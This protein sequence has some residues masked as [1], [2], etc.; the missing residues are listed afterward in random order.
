MQ[1]TGPGVTFPMQD[2]IQVSLQIRCP[3]IDLPKESVRGNISSI[4]SWTL[5]ALAYGS[6][7]ASNTSSELGYLCENFNNLSSR[8][9][10][11]FPEPSGDMSKFA[12][13][14]ICSASKAADPSPEPLAQ[15]NL[16][17]MKSYLAA[18]FVIQGYN[19]NLLNSS[20]YANMCWYL[21][22]SLLQGLWAPCGDTDESGVDVESSFCAS[23]GYYGKDDYSRYT[24]A[25]Q[26]TDSVM[27]ADRLVTML[28]GK[29]L[30][31]LLSS[32]KQFEY[33]CRNFARYEP[34]IRSLGLLSQV[35]R[36]EICGNGGVVE[37]GVAKQSL[38][39]AM[40]NLFSFQ[41]LM[42]GN[43]ADYP[44]FL[45]QN[46]NRNGLAKVGLDGDKILARVC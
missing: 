24:N 35:A 16:W 7:T 43:A 15:N 12:R 6:I 40:T 22:S 13:E 41:L 5:A 9:S 21:E 11:A 46:L 25:T 36:E 18:S 29:V 42:G 19:G 30:K 37:L 14:A 2:I 27:E 28:M 34:G 23:A 4:A 10:T 26:A 32:E 20:Y 33:L 8:Y 38:L 31:L 39:T 3:A 45:C 44:T 17:Y 1:Y